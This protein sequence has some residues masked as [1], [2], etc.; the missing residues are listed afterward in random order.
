MIPQAHA[1]ANLI[2]LIGA[3]EANDVV[4][5]SKRQAKLENEWVSTLGATFAAQTQELVFNATLTGR[6]KFS[7]IDFEPLVMKH[8]YETMKAGLESTMRRNPVRAERLAAPPKGRVPRSLKS[9]REWWDKYRKQGEVPPRQ[10]EIAE[11]MK[12]AYIEKVEETWQ[13]WSRDFLS[14]ETASNTDAVDAIRKAADVAYSR[15][16]MIVETETTYH[17]NK[18]R[19]NVYDASPDVTHYL[20]VALRD[21]ATTKWCKTRQGLVYVKGDPLLDKETPPIHWNCRSELLPL[22]RQNPRH[23]ALIQDLSRARRH[24]SPEPL[25]SEWTGRK[26]AG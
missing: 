15:A 20:Y 3:R 11:R 22:T 17:F 21:H 25:P 1:I 2:S 10:R 13:Q 7:L 16:K 18:A 24:N 14:G 12:E 4:Q 9:L 26:R 8:A 5:L 19:R 23:L 6:M